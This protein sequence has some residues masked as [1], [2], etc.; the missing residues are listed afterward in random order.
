[1][2]T[3]LSEEQVATIGRVGWAEVSQV[4]EREGGVR[5]ER[6]A[7]VPLNWEVMSSPTTG[8]A[9][10]TGRIVVSQWDSSWN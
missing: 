5:E 10:V 2:R 8:A 6:I 4:R 9:T 1:M 7:I 3:A